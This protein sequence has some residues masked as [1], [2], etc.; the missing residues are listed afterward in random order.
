M[1]VYSLPD[2]RGLPTQ[3]KPGTQWAPSVSYING[4]YVI[5]YASGVY[6]HA[7]ECLNSAY[8]SS[9]AGPFYQAT[10]ELCGY[11]ISTGYAID[12]NIFRSTDNSL[13]LLWSY[14]V[15]PG[16]GG[17]E[18]LA[19]PL[20]STGLYFSG[21]QSLTIATFDN[22]NAIPPCVQPN[23]LINGQ[24]YTLGSYPV[25]ENPQ[26]AIDPSPTVYSG[27]GTVY[28]I[29]IFVSFGT[30]HDSY[31]YHTVEF[32]CATLLNGQTS[33]NCVPIEGEDITGNLLGGGVTIPQN[34]GGMSLLDPGTHPRSSV[35]YMLFAGASSDPRTRYPYY[36]GS[37]SV[38][39]NM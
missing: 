11:P 1:P 8:S 37:T 4:W 16:S 35:P 17:S 29:D 12:P 10:V 9:P 32:A 6:A 21:A 33:D 19:T 22:V 25:I 38:Y 13:W 36:E 5:W 26:A 14:E 27:D 28:N 2:V 15:G 7:G 34:P 31:A 39:R 23:C 20:D 3:D 24:G 18:I 30:W